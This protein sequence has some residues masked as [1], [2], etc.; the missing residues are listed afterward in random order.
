[1]SLVA[2]YCDFFMIKN[3]QTRRHNL[4]ILCLGCLYLGRKRRSK[5]FDKRRIGRYGIRYSIG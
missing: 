5:Y 2:F 4:D 3:I 1:M